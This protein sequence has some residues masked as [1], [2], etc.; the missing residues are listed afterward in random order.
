MSDPR[1]TVDDLTEICW[2]LP[3]ILMQMEANPDEEDT[4]VVE[5]KSDIQLIL[6][7]LCEEDMHRKVQQL[8][9]QR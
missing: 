1:G 9:R 8:E 5:I 6:S 7:A 2:S 4:T 3:G